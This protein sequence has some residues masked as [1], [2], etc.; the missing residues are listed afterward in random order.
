MWQALSSLCVVT[1]LDWVLTKFINFSLFYFWFSCGKQIRS[2]MDAQVDKCYLG[3]QGLP[4]SI[5]K[6][7]ETMFL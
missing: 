4:Q 7:T 2:E 6:Q 5:I 1:E 3:C